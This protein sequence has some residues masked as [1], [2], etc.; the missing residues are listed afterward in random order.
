MVVQNIVQNQQVKFIMF[1]KIEHIRLLYKNGQEHRFLTGL[2]VAGRD[3][4]KLYA[5]YTNQVF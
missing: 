5:L 4:V 1:H 3:F 2:V